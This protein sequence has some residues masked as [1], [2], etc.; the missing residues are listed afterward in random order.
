MG[1][2]QIIKTHLEITLQHLQKMYSIF[3]DSINILIIN[4]MNYMKHAMTYIIIWYEMHINMNIG[5]RDTKTRNKIIEMLKPLGVKY[6][7][8]TLTLHK[9]FTSIKNKKHCHKI[10]NI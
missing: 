1:D 2:T 9:V 5:V 10:V 4:W 3:K 6:K 7:N 8:K